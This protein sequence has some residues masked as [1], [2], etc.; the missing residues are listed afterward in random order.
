MLEFQKNKV[1]AKAKNNQK[2]IYILNTAEDVLKIPEDIF[3]KI[4]IS[5]FSGNYFKKI[6]EE[7]LEVEQGKRILK[8]ARQL[9]FNFELLDEINL[10]YFKNLETNEKNAKNEKKEKEVK[11]ENKKYIKKKSKEY[12]I[13]KEDKI[14]GSDKTPTKAAKNRNMVK[15]NKNLN[16]DSPVNYSKNKSLLNYNDIHNATPDKNENKLYFDSLNSRNMNDNKNCI[17]P[18]YNDNYLLKDFIEMMRNRQRIKSEE[19]IIN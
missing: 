12:K 10:D 17:K 16:Y 1:N 19:K 6:Y 11:T 2:E 13:K 18:D 5:N 3:Y 15:N 9:N 4:D 8:K 14:E 7:A